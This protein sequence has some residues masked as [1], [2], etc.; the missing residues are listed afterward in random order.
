MEKKKNLWKVKS[1]TLCGSSI[2]RWLLE[3][4][5]LISEKNLFCNLPL[6]L[7]DL[8]KQLDCITILNEFQPIS[9]Q[10]LARKMPNIP[11]I[12]RH[13][14]ILLMEQSRINQDPTVTTFQMQICCYLVNAA[15][16]LKILP[17]SSQSGH[18]LCF[19]ENQNEHV[20]F[21]IICI[22]PSP[23]KKYLLWSSPSV[24]RTRLFRSISAPPLHP[25]FPH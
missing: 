10:G 3:T 24:H 8:D 12:L 19:L 17:A 9:S 25:R 11:I 13:F 21:G 2:N 1:T 16:L 6:F 4:V 14:P 5:I 15:P 7:L 18:Y 20:T 22:P 23:T